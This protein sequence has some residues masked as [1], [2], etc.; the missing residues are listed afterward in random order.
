[1]IIY[2]HNFN[3]TLSKKST[4]KEASNFEWQKG[5]CDNISHKN[6]WMKTQIFPDI[7]IFIFFPSALLRKKEKF[8]QKRHCKSK[9]HISVIFW[10]LLVPLLAFDTQNEWKSV[11][12]LLLLNHILLH[13][14]FIDHN[15]GKCVVWL[16]RNC[17][18][19]I[20][21]LCLNLKGLEI[22]ENWNFYDEN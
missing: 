9:S 14:I 7:G 1:M 13:N 15:L 16:P 4:I 18:N 20:E 21:F 10:F 22:Y 19:C 11:F 6:K 3:S 2:H 5:T 8:A 12:F 17:R